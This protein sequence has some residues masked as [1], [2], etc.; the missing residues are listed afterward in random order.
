[1][2]QKEAV[3]R[4]LSE[5]LLGYFQTQVSKRARG[6]ASLD[7]LEFESGLLTGLDT[8]VTVGKYVG[9]NLYIAYTQNFSG[10]FQPAFRVEYYLDRRNELLAERTEAGR[11]SLRYR[12]KLRY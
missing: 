6:F 12:F 8:K 2:D 9:R 11:Y 1:M 7:Y 10:D 3:T 5:R 4:L